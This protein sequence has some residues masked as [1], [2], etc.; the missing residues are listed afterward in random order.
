MKHHFD[1]ALH[2]RA[3][4]ALREFVAGRLGAP[5]CWPNDS[6]RGRI[7]DSVSNETASIQRWESEGGKTIAATALSNRNSAASEDLHPTRPLLTQLI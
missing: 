1:A 7:A 3:G 2:F 4:S 5:G 6:Y